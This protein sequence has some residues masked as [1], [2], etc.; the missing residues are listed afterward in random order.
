MK[1][2]ASIA[3]AASAAGL[4]GLVA[5][6]PVGYVKPGVSEAEYQQDTQECVEIARHQAFRDYSVFETRGRFDRGFDNHRRFD[7]FDTMVLSPGELEF[8]YRRLCML[9]RGYEIA[10]L[11]DADGDGVEAGEGTNGA[12]DSQP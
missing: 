2:L 10:P 4:L 3:A 8:R 5:C 7:T 9:S 12:D 1:H 6:A 11:E